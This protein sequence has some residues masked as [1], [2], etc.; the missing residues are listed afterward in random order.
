MARVTK[1]SL[2]NIV[3][4]TKEQIET[5]ISIPNNTIIFTTDELPKIGQLNSIPQI[6]EAGKSYYATSSNNI[7]ISSLT[8]SNPEILN[9]WHFVVII[10]S[11]VITVSFTPT[12]KWATPLPT[13]AANK[14]YEFS[15]IKVGLTYLGC[16]VTY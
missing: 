1:G 2:N 4:G 16:W 14:I 11:T 15:I 8:T 3:V 10:E 9:S 5:D 13:F 6:L 7:T 12:I